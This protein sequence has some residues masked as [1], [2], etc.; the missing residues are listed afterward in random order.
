MGVYVSRRMQVVVLLEAG[1]QTTEQPWEGGRSGPG[2]R[3]WRTGGRCACIVDVEW[4]SLAAGAVTKM[5][6]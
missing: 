2:G 5:S 4:D 3:S 6:S 1:V